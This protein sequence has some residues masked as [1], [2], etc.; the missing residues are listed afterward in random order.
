MTQEC[1][2]AIHKFSFLG[3]TQGPFFWFYPKER[4]NASILT[5]GGCKKEG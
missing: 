3:R 1:F 5:P 2:N 4:K